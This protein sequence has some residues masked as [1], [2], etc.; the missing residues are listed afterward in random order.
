MNK[1]AFGR[2]ESFALRYSWL[3]KGYQTEKYVFGEGLK[4][5]GNGQYTWRQEGTLDDVVQQAE[6]SESENNKIKKSKIDWK[7]E[8]LDNDDDDPEDQA[9][10]ICSL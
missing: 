5:F 3:T 7:K 4:S 2:H 1:T 9:C 6:A 10:L 8:L